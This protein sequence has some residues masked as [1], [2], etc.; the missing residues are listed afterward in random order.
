MCK[1]KQADTPEYL[2]S[3][4]TKEDFEKDSRAVCVAGDDPAAGMVLWWD[5]AWLD[6]EINV[7]GQGLS[8]ENLQLHEAPA[9]V[10]IWTGRYVHETFET[11][12][13][14][15]H[16]YEAVG[17]FRDLTPAEWL[18]LMRGENPLDPETEIED[19]DFSVTVVVKEKLQYLMI[20]IGGEHPGE[21][22]PELDDPRGKP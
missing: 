13:G 15:E 8:L 20:K 14:I 17:D 11:E 4:Y 2:K 6:R 22:D 21:H 19:V 7:V 18:V 16:D 9:G 1:I 3:P 5:G 12:C 10:S